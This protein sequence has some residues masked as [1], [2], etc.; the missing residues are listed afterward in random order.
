MNII[1]IDDDR[2]VC[3]SLKTILQADPEIHVAALGSSGEDAILL[4]KQYQPDIVLMDI[5]MKG[6]SGLDAGEEILKEFPE[7]RILYLTTF[8][9]NAYIIRALHMGAKGYL[10]KQEVENIIPALKAVFSGQ[11]VFGSEIV[12]KLPSLMHTEREFDFTEYG[13]SEREIGVIHL[14][15]KGLSNKEIADALHLSEGTVRNYLSMILD[16]L[17]LRDRTQL[18][19]FYFTHVQ[20]F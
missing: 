18:A 7:V 16:K 14:V 17:Q 9:D 2:L 10:I 6:I 19:V 20:E 13:I 12:T 11:V 1:I 15:A 8:S 4:Y 3:T 5:Q